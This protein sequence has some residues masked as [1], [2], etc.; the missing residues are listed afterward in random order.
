[1]IGTLTVHN[2]EARNVLAQLYME[3]RLLRSTEAFIRR[4][5]SHI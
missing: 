2:V 5:F 3:A 4:R 1:M